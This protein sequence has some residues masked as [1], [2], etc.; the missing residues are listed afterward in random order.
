[1][2]LSSIIFLALNS[3]AST[4]FQ[5]HSH[6]A[7]ERLLRERLPFGRAPNAAT[8]LFGSGSAT[9][10][11]VVLKSCDDE[12][13]MSLGASLMLDSFWLPQVAQATE[14]GTLS[15]GSRTKLLEEQR[16]DLSGRYGERM[17]KRLMPSTLLLATSPDSDRTEPVGMV[18][19]EAVLWDREG[20]EV[21]LNA[22]SEGI[23]KSALSSLGP[24]QRRALKDANLC[25]LCRELLKDGPAYEP[26]VVLA[27]LAVDP[28][29][30]RSG[31]GRKLCV[32][33]GE[34]ALKEIFPDCESW[35]TPPQ[36]VLQVEAANDGARSLYADR[37]GYTVEWADTTKPALRI[38]I[39]TGN[40]VEKSDVELIT[41]SKNLV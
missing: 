4:A 16:S 32:A 26:A 37:M 21:L 14:E 1:M 2:F 38:D 39:N 11:T 7:P 19:I 8:H 41:M 36:M 25:E 31:I 12:V 3:N 20:R 15:D 10:E 22:A 33:A 40:F 23:L 29:I 30:R 18:G 28:S 34:F 5:F 35:D 17:G 24:K 9:A 27:N 13:S 6:D